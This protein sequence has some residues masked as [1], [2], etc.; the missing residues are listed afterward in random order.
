M[1]LVGGFFKDVARIANA[2]EASATYQ[3]VDLGNRYG[4]EEGDY[5]VEMQ[6]E[7]E[8]ER[9]WMEWDGRDHNGPPVE[10]WALVDVRYRQPSKG[11]R[12]PDETGISPLKVQ[13]L[14]HGRPTNADIVGWRLSKD[15]P[16]APTEVEG[17]MFADPSTTDTYN[18]AWIEYTPSTSYQPVGNRLVDA[19]LRDGSELRSVNAQNLSWHH[20]PLG[21]GGSDSLDIVAWRPVW[22]DG[23]RIN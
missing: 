19:K 20:N 16:G 21:L 14:H 10:P 8:V 2:L 12:V 11:D 15:Q 23:K 6:P 18:G 9:P 5:G 13:W 1:V 7:P 22:R 17:P 3:A 4:V